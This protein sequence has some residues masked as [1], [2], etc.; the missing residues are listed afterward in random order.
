MDK[1]EA[2]KVL[3]RELVKL[4]GQKFIV[5]NAYQKHLLEKS[6]YYCP[7]EFEKPFAFEFQIGF[8]CDSSHTLS[9]NML[10]KTKSDY[11]E[12]ITKYCS[13]VSDANYIFVENSQSFNVSG[14]YSDASCLSLMGNLSFFAL[15]GEKEAENVKSL[16]YKNVSSEV[17]QA[18]DVL[19][20]KHFVD[21]YKLYKKEGFFERLE[22]LNLGKKFVD[23][24]INIRR[25]DND[26]EVAE[27]NLVRY[28]G[29]IDLL[30]SSFKKLGIEATISK[31]EDRKS[32]I[33]HYPNYVH[34]TNLSKVANQLHKILEINGTQ[35]SDNFFNF[36]FTLPYEDQ[37]IEA[38]KSILKHSP[39]NFGYTYFLVQEYSSGKHFQEYFDC[40]DAEKQKKIVGHLKSVSKKNLD[41]NAFLWKKGFKD[42]DVDYMRLY[43]TDYE[44]FI[45]YFAGRTTDEKRIMLKDI[46]D[47]DFVNEKVTSW[48]NENY[49]DI[50][51]E[52][53]LS[54]G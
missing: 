45:D 26:G 3:S 46:M 38:N 1:D 41:H 19:K 11:K 2:T 6:L 22:E 36:V 30:N 27:D 24:C 50:I 44:G 25:G 49:L 37:N 23:F 42:I 12:V 40:L 18:I 35:I 14:K 16:F 54:D 33:S 5:N 4:K 31:I 28:V 52:V 20:I 8:L 21:D 10:E 9:H 13:Q 53:G 43:K 34:T 32:D 15:I 39:T 47:A 48:L 29:G 17:I 7:I 51:R